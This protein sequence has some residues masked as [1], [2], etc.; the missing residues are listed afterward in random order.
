MKRRAWRLG[1]LLAVALLG[2]VMVS[3]LRGQS[4]W[5]MPVLGP[6]PAG[7][8]IYARDSN[9]L[10][11]TATPSVTSIT[12][13]SGTAI[14]KFTV[15]ATHFGPSAMSALAASDVCCASAEQVIGG[16]SG[17]TLSDAVYMAPTAAG[18]TALCPALSARVV[19]AGNIGVRYAQLTTA[20]C[21]P[22]T[23]PYHF[24][25]IRS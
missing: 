11:A 5:Q 24:V 12:V 18:N 19:S 21:T 9:N 15:Y 22:A 23:G 16:F 7:S 14:S 17:L 6:V 4:G 25:A 2:V 13:G 20:L 1:A 10:G 8:L 3:E